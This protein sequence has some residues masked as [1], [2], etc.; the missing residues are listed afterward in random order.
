[1]LDEDNAYT[2]KFQYLVELNPLIRN[3]N[4]QDVVEEEKLFNEFID[5]KI[6]MDYINDYFM[7]F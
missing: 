5:E 3:L 2:I 4:I 6:T 7:C 1:M